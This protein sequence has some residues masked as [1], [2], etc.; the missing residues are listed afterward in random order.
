[1]K[2]L[3]V[4]AALL[5][6]VVSCSS[7]GSTSVRVGPPASNDA[8]LSCTNR[9]GVSLSVG[10][11]AQGAPTVEEALGSPPAGVKLPGGS[12]VAS[13]MPAQP[14]TYLLTRNGDAV[15]TVEVSQVNGG[16]LITAV[17]TCG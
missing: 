3:L 1:M 11:G 8:R 7:F 14:G 9:K 17:Q 15:G 12:L 4:A 16:W 2:R 6:G 5:L 13:E 10:V